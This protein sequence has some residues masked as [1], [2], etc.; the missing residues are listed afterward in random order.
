MFTEF[1]PVFLLKD[2]YFIKNFI[3]EVRQKSWDIQTFT[4]SLFYNLS[5]LT[6]NIENSEFHFQILLIL[7]TGISI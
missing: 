1:R 2:V 6:I 5:K 7:Q 4:I 3:S